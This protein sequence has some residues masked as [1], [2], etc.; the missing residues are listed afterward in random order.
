VVSLHSLWFLYKC[1]EQ[2]ANDQIPNIQLEQKQEIE[3][4]SKGTSHLH[5][6]DKESQDVESN[7]TSTAHNQKLAAVTAELDKAKKAHHD[8]QSHNSDVMA[9]M[10]AEND[11]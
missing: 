1:N 11:Q 5:I 6:V 3:D 8:S 4:S 7:M 9:E 2:E 10:K